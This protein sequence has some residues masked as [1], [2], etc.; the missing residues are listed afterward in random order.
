MGALVS[1]TEQLVESMQP[2]TSW[3][4][5]HVILALGLTVFYGMKVLI[6]FYGETHPAEID[7]R[8]VTDNSEPTW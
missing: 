6:R 1:L 5:A 7:L 8:E 4:K 2:K 3:L